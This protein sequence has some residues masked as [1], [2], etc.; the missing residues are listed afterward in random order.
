MD[1]YGLL[2]LGWSPH[3]AGHCISVWNCRAVV[4]RRRDHADGTWS[5]VPCANWEELE[6]EAL[7]AV[8][9]VG[10]AMNLSGL[11]PCPPELAEKGI[12]EE[13]Q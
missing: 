2:A 6:E 10:G 5:F 4:S 3:H 11:Y 1:V 7:E 13:Q 12:W 8:E 9:A